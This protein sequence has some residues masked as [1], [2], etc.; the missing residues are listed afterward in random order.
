MSIRFYLLLAAVGSCLAQPAWAGGG[1]SGD[2]RRP[3]VVFIIVDDVVRSDL[4]FLSEQGL[5]PHIDRL[6][7]EGVYFSRGYTASTVCTPSRYACLSGR[8]P[9][10]CSDP[11]F[12][13]DITPEGMTV[14]AFNTHLEIDRPNLPNVMQQAGYVTGI[15]GKWHI[16]VHGYRE[17][18]PPPGSDP[19]DPTVDAMLKENQ[20]NL[21]RA[22]K[23]YGF[24]YAA[25]LYAGNAMDSSALKNTGC[26]AH[27]MEWLTEGALTFIEENQAKPFFLYFATTLPHWPPPWESLKGDPRVTAAS[28]L[29]QPVTVQP[30]RQAVLDRVKKASL[31][32]RAAGMAWVDDG[33]GAILGKL[34]MLGLAEDTLV[35]FFNDHGME[36]A[37][38]NSL[39]DGAT[40]TPIIAYWPGRFQAGPCGELVQNVDFAPTIF[41]ACGVTPPK[42]M[43]LAGRSF[44][45]LAEGRTPD[46]WRNYTY[47]ELGYTRALTGKRWKYLAFRLPPGAEVTTEESMRL[48]K[49]FLDE[50]KEDHAW[51]TWEPDSDARISHTGGPPGGDFLNRLTFQAKPPYLANYY[52]PDQ[53]YDL[54]A[55][56]TETTNLAGKPAH[57]EQL[58]AMQK[59]LQEALRGLPG[60]FGEFD[61]RTKPT[62]GRS[63]LQ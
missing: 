15:V 9:S 62:S 7:R 40:R 29:D 26:T 49:T 46:N 48:Q 55:D 12:A 33:I 34:E 32:E 45:P 28:L 38:K 14:V 39:Y 52:D 16:G 60:T 17:N 23:T 3:N 56:P 44:L 50:V 43:A 63:G 30:P 4:G 58:A 19:A 27:N 57:A 42:D 47:S 2:R 35:I 36:N 13:R 24:D 31:P 51:V 8:Y 37:S 5:T 21:V 59:A 61:Q 41:D 11:A 10:Q 6:A 18:I 22:I 20:R 1:D 54:T 25:R 53:L